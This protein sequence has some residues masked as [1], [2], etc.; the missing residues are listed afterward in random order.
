MQG[1]HFTYNFTH[2]TLHNWLH[3]GDGGVTYMFNWNTLLRWGRK[4]ADFGEGYKIGP[5]AVYDSKAQDA[6][7]I[8]HFSNFMA[9]SLWYDKWV[10]FNI[11]C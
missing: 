1:I 10:T 7:V 11:F 2:V 5:M 4:Y 9:A 6:M 8:S 3:S